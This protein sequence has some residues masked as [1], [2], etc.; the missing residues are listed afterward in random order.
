MTDAAIELVMAY[1]RPDKLSE[2]KDALAAVGAPSLTVTRV[3]GRG[4]E[5]AK[6]EQWRGEEYT[7]D[8]REKVKVE[9][10]V[11]DVSSEAVAEAIT[12]AAHTGE[13]GDGRVFVLPVSEAYDVRTG[14]TGTDAV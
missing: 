9:C 12:D 13:P 2:V 8:L 1:V 5:S 14:A 4:R 10:V 3:S 11:S 7:V 6:T